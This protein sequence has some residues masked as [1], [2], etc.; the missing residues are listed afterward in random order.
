MAF[1][2]TSGTDVLEKRFVNFGSQFE[3]V[4]PLLSEADPI[5]CIYL[6]NSKNV[7]IPYQVE[8][9]GLGFKFTQVP[10]VHGVGSANGIDSFDNFVSIMTNGFKAQG[11]AW[12]TVIYPAGTEVTDYRKT[13][14][15]PSVAKNGDRYFVQLMENHPY[16]EF[17]NVTPPEPHVL[18]TSRM[19]IVSKT[20]VDKLRGVIILGDSAGSAADRIR[21]YKKVLGGL[22]IKNENWIAK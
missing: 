11:G 18:K 19:E 9:H 10:Y 5:G 3:Q 17:V 8:K 20:P 1:E 13:Y 21:E 12:N 7:T 2:E 15:N 14:A 6:K 16:F 22:N 4:K